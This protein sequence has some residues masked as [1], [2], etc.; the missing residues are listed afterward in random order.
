MSTASAPIY[1]HKMLKRARSRSRPSSHPF[2]FSLLPTDFL[3]KICLIWSKPH[4]YLRLLSP[5]ITRTICTYL[6]Y[7]STYVQEQDDTVYALNFTTWIWEK[8]AS[9]SVLDYGTYINIGEKQVFMC[10]GRFVP[11]GMRANPEKK[12]AIASGKVR[13]IQGMVTERAGH[14]AIYSEKTLAVYVFG[15]YGPEETEVRT[16][17]RYDFRG[18]KWR[19]IA[20]MLELE[21]QIYVCLLDYF[22]YLTNRDMH[23]ERYSM[24]SN[25]YTPLSLQLPGPKYD[26]E[27]PFIYNNKLCV[28]YNSYDQWDV[29]TGKLIRHHAENG[30]FRSY[31]VVARG[32]K[33][34][35]L[36]DE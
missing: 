31:P 2:D 29:E 17:E 20:S 27:S 7:V 26:A 12:A 35:L 9:G 10:G 25:T 15:G 8:V 33:V 19:K 6:D 23:C 16:A 21:G 14:E 30:Y 32:G 11:E 36:E 34:Y 1:M 18:R 24:L 28:N 5:N 13:K 3:T 4:C 22:I